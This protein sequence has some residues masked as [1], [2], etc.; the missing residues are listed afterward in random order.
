[1][2]TNCVQ[3]DRNHRSRH[4]GSAWDPRLIPWLCRGKSW[5]RSCCCG[6]GQLRLSGPDF[7]RGSGAK[8]EMSWSVAVWY[9]HCSPGPL[10]KRSDAAR[11]GREVH[12]TTP[13]FSQTPFCEIEVSMVELKCWEGKQVNGLPHLSTKRPNGP[14]D[15]CV[16]LYRKRR[17]HIGHSGT[18]SAERWLPSRQRGC[19][20]PPVA[21]AAQIVLRGG[22][23][24]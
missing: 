6:A 18:V 9:W 3:D 11:P 5:H 17:N 12:S 16:F 1:M 22:V 2:L 24:G 20:G 14:Q 19:R 23:G 13:P 8:T 15:V 10:P 21:Y 4:T 7:G